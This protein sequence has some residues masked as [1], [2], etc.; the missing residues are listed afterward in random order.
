MGASDDLAKP[1]GRCLAFLQ[2]FGFPGPIYP[3]NPRYDALLGLACSKAITALPGR[4]DLVVLIVPAA[5]VAGYLR[6]AA[7]QG[8]R[9]AIV[10]S[11]GFAEAGPDGVALQEELV[12]AARETGLAVLGPNCLGL[13]D[14]HH[15]LA[16]TFTTGLITETP[17]QPGPIAF[18]SQSGAMGAALFTL[19]QADGIG[20]GKFISSGNEA[21]LDFADFLDYL[22]DDADVSL[23]LGYIE[24]IGRGRRFVAAARRA[25]AAGKAVAVLKVGQSDAGVR[26]A[27][28]HTGALVGS[29]HVYD[30][31]F[32]R[33][34]V[35]A[36]SDLRTLLDIAVALP[37]QAH[38]RGPRVGIVSMSGGAGV[39]IADRCSAGGLVVAPLAEA[40]GAALRLVLPAYAGIGNP[41]DYGAI[42]GDRDAIEATVA[43]VAADPGVDLVVVF[44][45][46]SGNLADDIEH[47]LARVKVRAGK[48]LFVAWLGGPR[49][50]IARLRG[51]G[52]PAFDDP[53]RAVDA[54]AQLVRAGVALPDCGAPEHPEPSP[55]GTALQAALRGFRARGQTVLTERDLK[56]LLAGYGVPVVEEIAV[57]SA[58][59]AEAAARRLAR[60]V[61]I[62]ADAPDLVHKSDAGAVRLH[63]S[64]EDAARAYEE[65]TANAARVVGIAG[66]R[67]AVVQPM[68]PTGVEM[69][70][71]L[72]LDPQFGPTVTVG[73]GGVASEALGDVVTELAPIDRGIARDMLGR[74]RGAKLLG[75]FRG[76]PARDVDA[77]ADVL[78]ALAAFGMDAGPLLL[79]LDINP[80]ITLA[81]GQGCVAVDAVGIL[82]EAPALSHAQGIGG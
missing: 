70:A 60:P 10:C 2:R 77:L 22:A 27:R 45:G 1:G 50:G 11:S 53:G 48:P 18:L 62:K 9:A 4:A 75:A 47:R 12:A 59:G 65:V 38:P 31:A 79:E 26:A 17:V 74:L 46:L 14:L 15:A 40:T 80:V 69:L 6:D 36:V 56:P 35:L 54:A 44:I 55:R 39:M 76:A 73:L 21:V 5:L 67:G 72:R 68:A 51:L 19:A 57:A 30:A 8:A 29:A 71:G 49:E 66:V 25:R 37:G 3:V 42:Y 41:V 20:F 13:L 7:A 78:V 23:L 82:A 63:V 24:G 61:A 52:V 28:S 43:A 33:A 32:R 34:G 16:A 64:A 58:R 81:A